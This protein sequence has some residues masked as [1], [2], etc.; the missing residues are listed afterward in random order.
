MK[1]KVKWNLRNKI[2]LPTAMLIILGMAASTLIT[3]YYATNAI[4][5]VSENRFEIQVNSNAD[6]ISDW[7]DARAVEVGNW[8]GNKT[9][10]TATQDSFMGKAA[11][12]TSAEFLARLLGDYKD[13]ESIF[14]VSKAGEV[15]V[16]GS[17]AE[18][19]KQSL[20]SDQS[21]Q[22]ALR[23]EHVV[24]DIYRSEQSGKV[25]FN[26]LAPVYPD[27]VD[28]NANN[29]QGILMCTLTLETIAQKFV[30]SIKYGETGYGFL[31]AKDGDLVV[32]PDSSLVL[33]L[34]TYDLPFGEEMMSGNAKTMRYQFKGVDKFSAFKVVPRSGWRLVLTSNVDEFMANAY[35]I[36]NLLGVIGI[37]VVVFVGLGVWLLMGRIV[38]KP[39]HQVVGLAKKLQ[40]GD[41]SAQLE[42]GNDELG[43]MGGAL[44]AVVLGMRERAQA[45]KGIAS[46]DL[47]QDIMVASEKDVLGK[48]LFDM[49]ESL[50]SVVGELTVS[51][52]QVDEGARQISDSSQSLAQ[53]ATE[54]ASS[55][56]EISASMSEIS[57]QTKTNADNA[58]QANQLAE[59]ARRAG[60]EGASR[61]GE[62][63]D[64]MSAINES[65]QQIAKIIKTIDDIAFQTNLLALNAAVEA[66]RAG[67]HGKGFAVV[68]Q[69]VRSLAARSAKAA[70]ET[71]DLIEGSSHKVSDGNDIAEK[72]AE[73]LTGIN[74][75]I[76]KV[77]DLVGEIAAA[78]NEQA[79]GIS[80][81]NIG[82]SQI[83]D[84]TQ[85]N[86]ANAEETSAAAQALSA[87]STQVQAQLARFKIKGDGTCK[88]A[89]SGERA[90]TV[91]PAIG[92]KPRIQDGWGQDDS[93]S[94]TV[95]PNQLI[96]LDDG[97]FGKY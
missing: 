13:Y 54:Q 37:L 43:E 7:L 85:Q 34:N 73:A 76:T 9:L 48:A 5:S 47:C 45:A 93:G 65:S 17:I 66:A 44:N 20:S 30:N 51:G 70:Q 97:E 8:A 10:S 33:K 31:V 71:A 3:N 36:R 72:T 82:L 81:I 58:V 6:R 63:M 4:N 77:A 60:D 15:I 87:Q 86:T 19:K 56:E 68:A 2:I 59:E 1:F 49:V 38:I 75:T 95:E 74:D 40:V 69:E 79:Q 18:V 21:F 55:L 80:Q 12:K 46:G 26:L 52:Q 39:V 84:A 91:R 78:S 67:V 11:R 96:A 50:N 35:K 24:S 28:R 27:A 32:H 92:N 61:M 41:L 89:Y 90:K 53:G 64:A 25:V 94:R 83:D 57:T 14:L 88:A 22:N 16:S 42:T 62:M 29:V 23:G